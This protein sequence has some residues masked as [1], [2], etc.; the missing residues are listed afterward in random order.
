MIGSSL[1]QVSEVP[2]TDIPPTLLIIPI[3]SITL[4]MIY[5]WASARKITKSIPILSDSHQLPVKKTM[6][7][8]TPSK[9]EIIKKIIKP[10]EPDTIRPGI[11]IISLIITVVVAGV[12]MLIGSTVITAMMSAMPSIPETSSFAAT[13]TTIMDNVGTAFNLL[14]LGI[15]VG[16]AGLII[17]TLGRLGSNDY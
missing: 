8:D 15:F 14:A 11:N 3:I 13:Q 16:A 9:N 10:L 4:F 7:P 6:T 12:V 2:S 17:M 1:L 5:R